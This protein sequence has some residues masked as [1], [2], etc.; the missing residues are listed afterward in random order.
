MSKPVSKK[1]GYTTGLRV[2]FEALAPIPCGACCRTIL[3][4][5]HFKRAVIGEVRNK[6]TLPACRQCEPFE[7]RK[8]YDDLT[9]LV[10]DMKP[11]GTRNISISKA[12]GNYRLHSS[13]YNAMIFKEKMGLACDSVEE[14]LDAVFPGQWTRWWL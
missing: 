13:D 8:F 2:I 4:G 5:E 6:K 14:L 1:F 7:E 3:P 12:D 9:T 10:V 11:R